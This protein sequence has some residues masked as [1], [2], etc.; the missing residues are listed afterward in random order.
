M[1]EKRHVNWI[2][3]DQE[4]KIYGPFST[5]QILAQIERGYF[6]GSEDVATYP[7][8]D[9]ISISTSPQF[10]D[11]LLEV[12]ERTR[13]LSRTSSA[14]HKPTQSVEPEPPAKDNSQFDET[15]P[16]QAEDLTSA[17]S[18]AE[19]P[20]QALQPKSLTQESKLPAAQPQAPMAD[21]EI[22][23]LKRLEEIE[24]DEDDGPSPLRYLLLILAI[25]GGAAAFYWNQ[26]MPQGKPKGDRV[27]LLAPRK[28]QPELPLQ[29]I[30]E[31]YRRALSAFQSDLPSGYLKAQDDLIEIVEGIP[32]DPETAVQAVEAY[33]ILCLTYR[34]LWTY[35]YQDAQDMKAVRETLQEAKRL[36]PAGIHGVTCEA[37]ML[38]LSGRY[39]EADQ[40]AAARLTEEG[41]AP[42]LFEMRGDAYVSVRDYSSAA[43]YFER[44]KLLWPAWQKISISHARALAGL[45][46]FGQ[47]VNLYKTVLATVP[48][49]PVAKIEMGLIEAKE[50]G[51][52][53]TAIQLL[54]SALTGEEKAPSV[55]RSKAWLALAQIAEER[56]QKKQAI[57]YARKSYDLNPGS[58]AAR[59]FL[60][61]IA[62]ANAV[63]NP[64]TAARELIY[65]ADQHA[66]S[67]DCLKA[68][69]E[70]K[71][72]FEAD[73]KIGIAAMKA[74]KCL[75]QLNQS[76]EAIE[77]MKK[78]IAAEPSLSGAYV[79]L[80]DYYA[81]RYDYQNAF[82]VLQRIQATQPNN[83]EVF[84]GF[85][86]IE[87]R[88]NNFPGAIQFGNRA[89]KLYASDLETLLVMAKA[90]LGTK[91]FS[92]ATSYAMRALEIDGSSTEAQA[93]VGRGKAGT[94]GIETGRKYLQSLLNSIILTQGQA[95]PPAA[96]NY[97][98][99]IAEMY[100]AEE[101]YGVAEDYARQAVSLDPNHKTALLMVGKL[102]Q[103]QSLS[104]EALEFYLKAAVLDPND[105]DPIFF[106]GNIYLDVGKP[107]DAISQYQRVL[108]VNQRYPRANSQM[109]QALLR[110]KQYK[111]ALQAANQE[112]E[113][114]PD[115]PDAYLLAG[116]ANY[117]LKQYTACA[118]EYQKAVS[119]KAGSASV[120]V[121]MARCH[122]LNGS[123]D[124]A[125]SL[126][127]QA[128]SIE[129]GQPDLYKE[130]GA[131]FQMRGQGEEA[132][133][134]YETYLRLVPNATDKAMVENRI[135]KIQA[136]DLSG[137][138]P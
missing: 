123:L 16:P 135:R 124:S 36:D 55:L 111:E 52:P 28:N 49:H 138:S 1:K 136:G 70:Y 91:D 4:G 20:M 10:Y 12:L 54:N 45:T 32:K 14:I 99:A 2:V 127:R 17:P 108:R 5:D 30:Q 13:T 58:E 87:L 81:L 38:I 60:E 125:Q 75:W 64:K 73:P 35:S 94:D 134:A 27:R 128:Q 18:L 100:L 42:I 39:R 113:I 129:S 112:K 11:K 117:E 84:R 89:L 86:Q 74:G 77:W 40:L 31:K 80:A 109:G 71:T 46:Q 44:A 110:L 115:L 66:K 137:E 22:T 24:E 96:I 63:K 50:F 37:V 132:I 130:Q 7:G 8:G 15:I 19:A 93:I 41:Q 65:T 72:A 116:E 122:R 9:W 133:T 88:R 105:A 59:E 3:R 103:M 107:S 34:E 131:I 120:L 102:L 98:L 119:K 62:G 82:A 121:R 85:A 92:T 97:R 51:H 76:T 43:T 106:T 69:A 90:Y 57:E 33:S 23:N 101:K 118:V 95:P 29:K 79:E 56:N 61:R 47:A 104:R 25:A 26:I 67:G 78:A 21:I 48:Q 126:L 6:L 53:D 68:Q 114:N 83:Y